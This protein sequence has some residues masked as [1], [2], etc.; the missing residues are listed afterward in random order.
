MAAFLVLIVGDTLGRGPRPGD[1]TSSRFAG[2]RRTGD[3]QR[4]NRPA[5]EGWRIVL[6][7]FRRR[8][9]MPGKG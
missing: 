4:A 1:V 7:R 8:G 2:R 3:N 6:D 5:I 9:I